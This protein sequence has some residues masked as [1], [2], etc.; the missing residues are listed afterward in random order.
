M[1]YT[2]D[3]TVDQLKS[4]LEYN[5]NT[6]TFYRYFKNFKKEAGGLGGYR[7]GYVQIGVLGKVYFAH[8]L[9]WLYMTGEWPKQLI[10]HIDGNSTNNAWSNLREATHS[11]NRVNS[12]VYKNSKSGIKGVVKTKGGYQARLILGTY[13]TLE[14]ARNAYNTAALKLH[15]EFAHISVQQ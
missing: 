13:K 15:G 8:R 14:E 10:D 7:D 4:V 5:P 2:N 6:G 1:K 12:R 3:L 9:A 11:Q